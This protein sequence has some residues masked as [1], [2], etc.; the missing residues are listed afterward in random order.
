M[1]ARMKKE[2]LLLGRLLKK[3]APRAGA[4]VLL[5][6]EW[7][8]AGQIRFSNGRKSYFRYNTLDLNPVGAADIA[9]D[10]DYAAFFMRRMGYPAL[11]GR[12]FFRADFAQALGSTRT[13]KEA[14]RYAKKRYPLVVK[15]NS[16]SHG[17]GVYVVRSEKELSR[18][19]RA[20]FKHDRVGIVQPY[21]KGR[22]YRVVVLDGKVIS[23]Y[24]RVPLHVIGDGR[25]SIA[26]LLKRKA[27]AFRA[28]SRDTRIDTRDPR[29]A[30]KLRA[31][32]LSTRSTPARGERVVLLD[33]ANLSSGG[34]ALDVTSAIHP[35]LKRMAI[36]LTR[37]MGLRMCGV[38]IMAADISKRGTRF[39]ILEI[40]AA[41][42]LDHY[43]KSGK[44]QQRIVED[45][46]LRVLRSLASI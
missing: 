6:P 7:G 37:D 38:D 44:A 46:Y 13:L 4:R 11:R 39:H 31:Q 33:N 2:S 41:P 20:V 24:E 35:S 27:R 8:V 28:A 36:A 40:N 3:L 16:G 32:R 18:A 10:K 5:E 1:A 26:E 43:V 14:V 17:E 34:S 25:S 29:I 21:V 9:K 30:H 22:D 19:L 12:T 45:L 15:P 23:A 42:G